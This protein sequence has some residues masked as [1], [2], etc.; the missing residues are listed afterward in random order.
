[1]SLE[2]ED[3]EIFGILGPNGAG[4]PPLSSASPGCGNQ[5]A[6]PSASWVWTRSGTAALRERVGVQLQE[7]TLRPQ[8]TVAETI[9]LFA[10]FYPQPADTGELIE[11]LGLGAKR[12]AYYRRLSGGQKTVDRSRW[13]ATRRSRSW[14]S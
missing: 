10:S 14:M 1:M 9:S 3:G 2:V 5:T 6:G 4:R 7:G 11:M 13:W 8:L 12:N